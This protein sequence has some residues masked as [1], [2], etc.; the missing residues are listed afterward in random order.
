M[1][2]IIVY[3]ASDGKSF[4]S[5]SATPAALNKEKTWISDESMKEAA[6]MHAHMAQVGGAVYFFRS[7]DDGSGMYLA[8]LGCRAI[9]DPAWRE[10]ATK[11]A[12]DY[13]TAQKA[14]Q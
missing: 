9:E 4:L 2:S 5:D 10:A 7:Q 8:K 13:L 11:L 1:R 6:T 14:V 3:Q 12:G